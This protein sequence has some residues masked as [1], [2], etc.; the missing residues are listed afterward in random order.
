M[1]KIRYLFSN[2]PIGT[3]ILS[4]PLLTAVSF[5]IIGG[6]FARSHETTFASLEE[7]SRAQDVLVTFRDTDTDLLQ[8]KSDLLQAISWKMG[9]VE[10]AKVLEEVKSALALSDKISVTLQNNRDNILGIGVDQADYDAII[11]H[12]N[13]YHA[14]LKKTSDMALV[15]PDTSIITLNDTLEKFNTLNGDLS[16]IVDK[17]RASDESTVNALK[18]TLSSSLY[19]VTGAIL[20]SVLVL[21][22]MSALIGREIAKP[23]Q[24][25]TGIMTGLA[26]GNLAVSIPD[27]SRRD[28]VGN[29]AKAVEVFKGGLIRSKALQQEQKVK[30]EAELKRAEILSSIVR[31]FESKITDVVKLFTR[32]SE[33]MQG[34]AESLGSSVETSEKTTSNVGHASSEAMSNVQTVATAVQEMAASIHEISDQISRTRAVVS[35]AVELTGHASAETGNLSNSAEKIGEIIGLIQDIAAQTNLL[36]LNATIEAARAG[37]AGKGFAVVASEV[38]ELASQT[39]KAT[40]QIAHNISSVQNISKSVNQA[41]ENIRKSIDEVNR[42]SSS[43]AVAVEQQ[44]NVTNEISKNMKSAADSVSEISENMEKVISAVDGVKVV[45]GK[46]RGTSDAM[47]RHIS[48]LNES[49]ATFCSGINSI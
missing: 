8:S 13:A 25:L 14:S 39:A 23:I 40:E 22:V 42:Y 3:K 46:V 11:A 20:I 19:S 48:G 28:E 30:Q 38:K 49:V 1:S 5:V 32:S 31:G 29:M 17:A 36:A 21:M 12:R 45:A 37:D 26:G 18:S 47:S 9:Y 2:L 7:A 6:F 24:S 15:D 44:S 43:V 34:A 4:I 10:N 41:I 33:D 35:S 16:R 27:T